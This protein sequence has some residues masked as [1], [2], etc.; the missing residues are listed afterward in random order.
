MVLSCLRLS[1]EEQ[2]LKVECADWTPIAPHCEARMPAPLLNT[3]PQPES[4]D[5]NNQMDDRISRAVEVRLP[6]SLRIDS[7]IN[8]VLEENQYFRELNAITYVARKSSGDRLVSLDSR[9]ILA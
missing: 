5:W 2:H 1:I 4:M 8:E 3:G 6:L 7:A 9:L